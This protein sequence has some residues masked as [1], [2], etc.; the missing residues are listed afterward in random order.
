MPVAC[1][2]SQRVKRAPARWARDSRPEAGIDLEHNGAGL[3]QYG[4]E[5]ERAEKSAQALHP[6]CRGKQE[7]TRC[8]RPL[9]TSPA[10]TSRRWCGTAPAQAPG[11]VVVAV[12][13]VFRP[14]LQLLHEVTRRNFVG[15]A[16]GVDEGCCAMHSDRGAARPQA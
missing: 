6:L 4:L 2:S 12:D 14:A 9:A 7:S 8:V 11:V 16:R 10:R 15:Q 13:G 3:R 5:T 1:W